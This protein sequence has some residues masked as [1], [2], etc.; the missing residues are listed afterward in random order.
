MRTRQLPPRGCVRRARPAAP[1]PP[2]TMYG[3]IHG[4]GIALGDLDHVDAVEDGDCAHVPRDVD[5]G[6]LHFSA[7]TGYG[8]IA[9]GAFEWSGLRVASVVAMRLVSVPSHATGISDF[10]IE[11]F[12]RGHVHGS[13]G[14]KES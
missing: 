8:S 12:A 4:M 6:R 5:A 9:G 11:R 14:K 7:P 2:H 1:E 10:A 3:A 13:Q